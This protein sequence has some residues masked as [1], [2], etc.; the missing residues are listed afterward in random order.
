M[1]IL[2]MDIGVYFII[3]YSRLLVDIILVAI[4]GYYINDY[5]WVFYCWML[6]IIN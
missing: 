2:L 1:H 3:G 4:G 5:W 6:V